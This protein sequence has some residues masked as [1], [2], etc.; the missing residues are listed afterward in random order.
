MSAEGRGSSSDYLKYNAP[1]LRKWLD[2][3]DITIFNEVWHVTFVLITYSLPTYDIINRMY[4][5]FESLKQ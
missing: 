3:S 2:I 4:Q 1:K 5:H